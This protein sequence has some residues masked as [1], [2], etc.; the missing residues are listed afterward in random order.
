M[1]PIEAATMPPKTYTEESLRDAVYDVLEEGLS[2]NQ[3]AQK[4]GVPTSTLSDRAS[5]RHASKDDPEAKPLNTLLSEAHEDRIVA[6]IL[7]QERLGFA[8]SQNAVRLVVLSLT[9]TEIG[10]H[11]VRRF[12][13]RRPEVHAKIG[14][15]QEATRFN[16]FTPRAVG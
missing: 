6:W 4:H 16:K 8:P 13:K 9:G 14:R 7:Q 3:A 5:G 12:V 11:W 15:K 2:I 1:Y 10:T